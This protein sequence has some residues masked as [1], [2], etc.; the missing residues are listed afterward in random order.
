MSL[1]MTTVAMAQINAL[2]Q[3]NGPINSTS[4]IYRTGDVGIG[5][6]SPTKKLDVTGTVKAR[7]GLFI[8]P[9]ADG[10]TFLS[11]TDRNIQCKVIAAGSNT[12]NYN[13][14]FN[15]YDFPSSNLD[16]KSQVF[17][18][19]SDRD[20]NSRW[21]FYAETN[22]TTNL[23]YFNRFQ[24][25]FYSL[26]E[27][28]DFVH[29]QL[30]KPNSVIT[31]GTDDYQDGNDVYRLSVNGKVRAESIKV[32][33][34]WADFVFEKDYYLPT[35]EEVEDYIKVNGHLKD[36]PSAKEVKANGID[37]GEMNKLLLQKI[38]ELTLYTIQLKKEIDGLKLKTVT[39]EK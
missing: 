20:D 4:P 29:L 8:N 15:V 2:Q 30:N 9:K 33:V 17:I 32:Y 22:G 1:L 37:L 28:N 14:L 36:I 19:A 26:T 25:Q 11:Y 6:T 18:S 3:W 13:H 34:G 24:S 12:S 21:R 16:P 35:L 5:N 31:I 38:E 10:S 27:S 39:D 7:E 23:K